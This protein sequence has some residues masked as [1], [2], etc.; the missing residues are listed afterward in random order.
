MFILLRHHVSRHIRECARLPISSRSRELLL[1]LFPARLFKLIRRATLMIWLE[2]CS[3]PWDKAEIL[4]QLRKFSFT[5]FASDTTRCTSRP[6]FIY[7]VS[8]II[9][10]WSWPQCVVLSPWFPSKQHSFIC[11]SHSFSLLILSWPRHFQLLFGHN[12]A[13]LTKPNGQI[14]LMGT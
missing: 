11:I 13:S 2:V 9:P 3:W 10:T 4:L 7:S 14:I 12:F 5:F 8:T 1:F 6:Y